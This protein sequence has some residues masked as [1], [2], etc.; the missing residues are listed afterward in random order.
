M[1]LPSNYP[2]GNYLDI[3]FQRNDGVVN[4]H[5]TLVE[6]GRLIDSAPFEIGTA[7]YGQVTQVVDIEL[8]GTD[9]ST[10]TW[11]L[12]V[13]PLTTQSG[14]AAAAHEQAPQA[15]SVTVTADDFD[16]VVL[17]LV[18]AVNASSLTISEAMSGSVI[19]NYVEA[20]VSPVSPHKIRLTGRNPGATFDAVLTSDFAGDGA[21]KTTI[22]SPVTEKIKVGLY[23]AVDISKGNGGYDYAGRPYLTKIT[24][25]TPARNI[26]GPVYFGDGTQPVEP[27]FALRQYKAGANIPYVKYGHVAAYAEKAIAL[28]SGPETVYVRHTDAGDFEAGMA[29]DAAG[30]AAGATANVWTGTPAEVNTTLYQATIQIVG[31][32][33]ELIS[34]TIAMTSDGSATPDEIVTGL[35]ADLA[36]KTRLTGLVTGSGTA[37]LVL[38][39]PDDGRELSVSSPG[40]GSIA[41]VETT[42]AVSTHTLHP[43]D[44]FFAPSIRIGSAPVAVP[45]V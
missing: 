13:T 2:G 27:G 34:E 28:S 21:T 39:G 22:A 14:T 38:T 18:A 40:P 15:V 32:N 16:D 29:T 23:Y 24:S 10:A 36:K 8:T 45:A 11:T 1:A 5:P 43:R 41:W 44:K 42:A 9:P 12:V 6:P 4:P 26:I 35:K 25:S 20:S 37:T 30:A 19:A 31:N 7:H 33:G 17:A 3:P